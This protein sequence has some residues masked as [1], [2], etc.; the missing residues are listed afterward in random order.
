M[1]IWVLT[2]NLNITKVGEIG[3]WL[4]GRCEKLEIQ[5]LYKEVSREVS[6][7]KEKNWDLSNGIF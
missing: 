7:E 4:K 2:F 5:T 3:N 1:I 6:R